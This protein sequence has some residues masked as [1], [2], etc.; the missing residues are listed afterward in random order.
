MESL[1]QQFVDSI[2]TGEVV[3]ILSSI[4]TAAEQ[5]EIDSFEV[6]EF[7]YESIIVTS[8]DYVYDPDVIYIPNSKDFRM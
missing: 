1:I 2:T 6:S 7:T 5:G 8:F 3:S 4:R